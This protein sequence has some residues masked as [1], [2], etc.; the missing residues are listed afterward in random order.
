MELSQHVGLPIGL[1]EKSKLIWF[2][3]RLLIDTSD[4]HI[5][6]RPSSFFYKTKINNVISLSAVNRLILS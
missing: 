1:P 5:Y 3:N 4:I 2:L 6:H